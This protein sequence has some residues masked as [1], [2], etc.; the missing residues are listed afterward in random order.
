[1]QAARTTAWVDELRGGVPLAVWRGPGGVEAVVSGRA[2]GVSEGPWAS[3]NLSASTGDRPA[4]VRENRR[5]LLVAAGLCA[6]RVRWCRQVHGSAVHSAEGLPALDLL[7]AAAQPPDGDGLVA[8]TPGL[9]LL[10]FAADC[11]PVVVARLDGAGHAV[12]HAGRR[13][14]VAG[15]VEATVAVLGGAA[16]AA[17]G[18][19]AGPDRYEVGADVGAELVDRFGPGAV[20]AHGTADLPYC[21]VR[22]LAAAGVPAVD[23]LDRCTIGDERLFSHRRDGAPGGRQALLAVRREPT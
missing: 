10:V 5:R 12:C 7:D 1:M 21:A 23:V 9:G 2:G 8:G 18:P 15:V 19:C 6:T 17:V 14:L 16:V 13:G 4:H 22:A 11:V 20:T 3:L